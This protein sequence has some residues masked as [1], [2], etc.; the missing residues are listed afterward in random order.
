MYLVLTPISDPGHNQP[1]CPPLTTVHFYPFLCHRYAAR[2]S[3]PPSTVARSVR[4]VGCSCRSTSTTPIPAIACRPSCVQAKP[5]GKEV[6]ADTGRRQR[7]ARSAHC[8]ARPALP[9]RWAALDRFSAANP[10][11]AVGPHFALA[12]AEGL[13]ANTEPHRDTGAHHPRPRFAGCARDTAA[14]GGRRRWVRGIGECVAAHDA[15]GG[16]QYPGC[17]DQPRDTTRPWDSTDLSGTARSQTENRRRYRSSA[18]E[19]S[20]HAETTGGRGS[21]TAADGD[22][23]AYAACGSRP[24]TASG[25]RSGRSSGRFV[26]PTANP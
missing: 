2:R 13:D 8:A 4:M 23:T 7:P 22:D 19:T 21:R 11:A 16:Q 3:P 14:G 24:T 18:G 25:T 5:R 6:R 17:R 26:P 1:P 20:A 12:G 10:R 9:S 15:S